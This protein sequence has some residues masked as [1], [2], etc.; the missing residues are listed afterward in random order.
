M[1]NTDLCQSMTFDNIMALHDEKGLVLEIHNGE[2]IAAY[3]E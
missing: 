1:L 2:V 3:F